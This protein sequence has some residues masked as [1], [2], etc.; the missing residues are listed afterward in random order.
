MKTHTWHSD[1]RHKIQL[2]LNV[3]NS[4]GPTS[5]R[6]VKP[7]SPQKPPTIRHWGK[8]ISDV[9]GFDKKGILGPIFQ[10][11]TAS[12]MYLCVGHIIKYISPKNLLTLQLWK[13]VFDMVSHSHS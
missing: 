6:L 9:T 2:F 13:I 4:D 7:T 12:E 5:P 1:L 8:L 3:L 10:F 11:T